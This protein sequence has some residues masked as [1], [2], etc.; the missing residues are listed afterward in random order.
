[1]KYDVS[2][3][4]SNHGIIKSTGAGAGAVGGAERC[5]NLFVSYKPSPKNATTRL[6]MISTWLLSQHHS[7]PPVINS[8]LF[9]IP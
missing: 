1:M 6:Q 7:G 9:I 8:K 4:F 5:G 2:Y 3:Q